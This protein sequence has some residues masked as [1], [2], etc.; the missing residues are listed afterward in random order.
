M[1]SCAGWV[2]AAEQFPLKIAPLCV[3]LATASNWLNSAS[4]SPSL[5]PLRASLTLCAD[6]II[7]MIVP[8]ITDAEY[9]NLQSKI[10]VRPLPLTSSR[11]HSLE[12][13]PVPLLAC[14]SSG[15]VPS[16]VRPSSPPPQV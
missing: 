11:P 5:S 10:T 12:L 16:P 3:S 8:Y 2:V 7:A 13:T 14:S 15:P 9:A 4:S 6:F 1:S